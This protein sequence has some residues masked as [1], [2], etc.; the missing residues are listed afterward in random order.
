[1][2]LLQ[3]IHHPE[4][5][6]TLIL[7]SETIQETGSDFPASVPELLGSIALK[8]I[9]RKL[10]PRRPGRDLGLEQHCTLYGTHAADKVIST[11]VLTPI[12]N[13]EVSLPYYHPAVFHI[14]FRYISAG[15][16]RLQIEVVSFPETPLDLNSR[17][18]RTC[19]ALLET[20]HRYG[21]GACHDYKKRVHHDVLVGREVYQDLYQI[22]R[23]RYKHLVDTWHESTDPLKHVFEVIVCFEN[24]TRS[25]MINIGHRNR[26][27]SHATLEGDV[28]H[29]N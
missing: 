23:A 25:F 22:M 6:S 19:L 15:D 11:V 28:W 1:M 18:Y 2:A 21:W 3:L 13:P 9:H 8:N 24:H 17:L 4:Y 16:P 27:L 29:A 12:L 7:R 26:H 10:L 14:A 5:N 20:V